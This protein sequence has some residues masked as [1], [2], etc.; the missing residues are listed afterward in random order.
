M[1]PFSTNGRRARA[2]LAALGLAIAVA[3]PAAAKPAKPGFL[4]SQSAMLTTPVA[5]GSVTPIITVGETLGSY[6]F[7]SIPDGISFVRNG[8]GTVDLYVNHET[9]TVP[10]PLA[11]NAGG[12]PPAWIPTTNANGS[13]NDFDNSQVSW[14]R[15]HQKSMGVLEASYVIP[16]SAG[17]HRFCSNFLATDEHGFDRPL[18]LTNEEGVDWV[19][20]SAPAFPAFPGDAG[21]RQIG[22][23]V[24]YDVEA[25][26]YQPIWGMGRL[27]H[28][29]SVAIPNYGHPV[30]LTTD[31]T[32]TTTPSQ[33]QLFSYIA[34]SADDVWNDEG[35][36]WAFVSD[37]P[38]ITRYEDFV[39]GETDSITGQFIQVPKLIATG[40]NPDGSEL[41]AGDVPASLGGPY[42]LPP[43]DGTWQRFNNMGIDGPQWVLEKWSQLN[44]VFDFVRLEDV[45]YDKRPGMS[46]VVYIVDS[47]RGAAP[48]TNVSTNGRIWEMVLDPSDPTQVDSL[49][50]LI[51]GDDRPVKDPARIHQ[52]DNIES[53]PNGLYI[54]EDPGSQQNFPFGSI[55]PGSA[56]FNPDATNARIWQYKLTGPDAGD[57]V[58]AAVVNQ[59]LDEGTTDVDPVSAGTHGFW[60]ASGIID[61][62]SVFGPGTFLVTIQ[63]H[64]LWV[65][66]QNAGDSLTRLAGSWTLGADT[67]PDW[68]NKREGGQL[69]LLRIPGA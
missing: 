62:S 25:G 66:G 11:A 39:P 32:F 67:F 8:N 58:V 13:Q 26:T 10:F 44:T 57:L 55:F 37:D 12:T 49:R 34:D 47:G 23:V 42:P 36:L 48:G 9:S 51:E 7:E 43:N 56:N 5:G 14:L 19:S 24:A 45:A 3:A 40:R 18:L 50:I 35:E 53:T 65:E 31:D 59:A 30:V 20:N 15:L 22:A 2:V 21:A 28:E 6:R 69:V 17:F 64:S 61:V 1:T 27:N 41:M 33:S 52:P 68:I 54:T 4:T 63:S 60:E 38:A 16:S 29:N 46:N